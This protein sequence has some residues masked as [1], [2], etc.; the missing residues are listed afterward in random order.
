MI[1]IPEV[2]DVVKVS[3]FSYT[4]KGGRGTGLSEGMII[5][6]KIFDE[7]YPQAVAQV[8]IVK[9][10]EDYE[11]GWRYWAIAHE[12]STLSEFLIKNAAKK[13]SNESYMPPDL[14]DEM[15]QYDYLLFVSEHYIEDKK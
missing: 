1:Y 2:G 5:D 12:D 10:W 4:N 9:A 3:K 6:G 15:N 11:T 7:R 8:K 13:H 14:A